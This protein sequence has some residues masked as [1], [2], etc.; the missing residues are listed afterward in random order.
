VDEELKA[1]QAQGF[2]LSPKQKHQKATLAE[3]LAPAIFLLRQ[4]QDLAKE[5]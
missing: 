1:L 5:Q 3:L 2:K 4:G